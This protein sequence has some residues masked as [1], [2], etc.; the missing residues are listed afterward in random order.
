VLIE[1]VDTGVGIPAELLPR[2]F[3]KF[4]QVEN[5]AQP[6]SMGSGLGLAIAREIVDAHGGTIGAE[7]QVGKGTTFRV[8]LPLEPPVTEAA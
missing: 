1:V 6:R 5:Q 3:D 8:V 7:S 2:V 4:F